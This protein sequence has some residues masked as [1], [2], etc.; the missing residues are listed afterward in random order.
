MK[1]NY[2]IS[3]ALGLSLLLGAGGISA[4]V[5]SVPQYYQEKDQWCWNASSQMVLKY[6][7]KT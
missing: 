6:Y 7:G 3:L 2:F 4:K 5:L 1:K